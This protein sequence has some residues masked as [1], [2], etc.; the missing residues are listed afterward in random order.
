MFSGWVWLEM[1]KVTKDGLARPSHWVC[2][3]PQLGLV[4]T[5]P[6]KPKKE[7]KERKKIHTRESVG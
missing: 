7:E 1:K 2:H 3:D 5:Q 6:K 4:V